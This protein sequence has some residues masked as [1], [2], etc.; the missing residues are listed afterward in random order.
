MHTP[1][2]PRVGEAVVLHLRTWACTT[3]DDPNH[4]PRI[5]YRHVTDAGVPAEGSLRFRYEM[6]VSAGTQSRQF[7]TGRQAG[8]SEFSAPST[9]RAVARQT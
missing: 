9:M 8:E 6:V 4:Y 5:I 3:C 2:Q 7:R 1:A